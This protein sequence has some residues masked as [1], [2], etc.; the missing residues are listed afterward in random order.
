M[1]L[2]VLNSQLAAKLTMWNE[3]RA[4]FWGFLYQIQKLRTLMKGG[5]VASDGM[6]VTHCNR[7]ATTLQQPTWREAILPA[8]VRISP[9][10]QLQ[11]TATSLQLLQEH[12][13]VYHTWMSQVTHEWVMLH[14]NESCY[15]WRSRVCH[16]R[17]SCNTL[18]PHCNHTATT[19]G[20][21]LRMT[22]TTQLQY[23]ATTHCN[24]TATTSRAF[25]LMWRAFLRMYAMVVY[26]RACVRAS[27]T[28]AHDAGRAHSHVGHDSLMCET[29]LIHMFR[30]VRT[31]SVR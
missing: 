23:T 29:W 16:K 27:F 5:H 22:Q 31:R 19:A 3:C 1:A 26:V 9:T 20:A 30:G 13:Y 15:T 24:H 14:M 17:H 10:T 11:H 21:F 28:F 18:Q 4:D 25:L 2:F 8:T 7:T 12:F 6:C